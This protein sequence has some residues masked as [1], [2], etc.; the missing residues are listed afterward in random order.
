[1]PKSKRNNGSRRPIDWPPIKAAYLE[2]QMVRAIA[3]R[4]GLHSSTIYR[5]ALRD[6]WTSARPAERPTLRAPR[7]AAAA[8][9]GELAQLRSL[10]AKL[11]ERL[12][13][14]IDGHRAFGGNITGARE[15]PAAL[16]LK[17]CQITEKIITME[18]RMA[19]ADAPAASR[20]SEQDHEIL[21]RF[22]RRN[23]VG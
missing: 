12:E 9:G 14:L 10:A 13:H 15:S 3:E 23:R 18:S 20:L 5:R 8:P 1:M 4:H 11:R 7:V 21:D 17:L 22:K 16:L 2:G 6:N 19:G